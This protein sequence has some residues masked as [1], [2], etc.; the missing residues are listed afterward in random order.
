[1][2]NDFRRTDE[3]LDVNYSIT[4]KRS[5]MNERFQNKEFGEAI[6]YARSML[7]ATC[8]YVY[9]EITGEEA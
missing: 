9:H 1:M 7:E 6:N 5:L 4:K 8:K 3:L 2:T